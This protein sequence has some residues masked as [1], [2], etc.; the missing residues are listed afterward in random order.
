MKKPH[1]IRSNPRIRVIATKS[2]A[3]ICGESEPEEITLGFLPLQ[4]LL[5]HGSIGHSFIVKGVIFRKIIIDRRHAFFIFIYDTLRD[6]VV[7]CLYHELSE[8]SRRVGNI[9]EIH[10][11]E[12]HQES[13]LP[14]A[15]QFDPV[16]REFL[17]RRKSSLLVFAFTNEFISKNIALFPF[18]L[19]F[20]S[21]GFQ[22]RRDIKYMKPVVNE[23]V[24]VFEF[25]RSVFAFLLEKRRSNIILIL[26]NI[27]R[28][29]KDIVVYLL[30]AALRPSKAPQI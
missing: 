8:I 25:L 30:S 15:N 23:S 3:H 27:R 26:R 4:F 14:N 18:S 9:H 1:G 21:H 19:N 5:N 10:H 24:F 29:S 11:I 12:R 28:A 22:G 17:K 13:V 16:G 2:E 6:N 20:Q 7:P